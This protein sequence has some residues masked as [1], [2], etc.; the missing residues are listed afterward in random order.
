[1]HRRWRDTPTPDAPG[2][3]PKARDD[4]EENNEMTNNE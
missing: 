3:F 1:M 2:M 4:E